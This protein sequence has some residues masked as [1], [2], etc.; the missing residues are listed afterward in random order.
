MSLTCSYE[1][2]RIGRDGDRLAHNP[3]VAGSN[4]V[5]ATSRNG[6]RRS[7]RGPFSCL[8]ATCLATLG[9]LIARSASLSW[10]V[11]WIQSAVD[12]GCQYIP[13]PAIGKAGDV[14][15][16]R[17]GCPSPSGSGRAARVGWVLLHWRV[18]LFR[19]RMRWAPCGCFRL[20]QRRP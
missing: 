6:P 16:M 13:R 11:G 20:P 14:V 19:A 8:L 1:T 5:P 2:E 15:F 9:L 17:P 4:P 3:E 18:H 7:L 12:E 10:V